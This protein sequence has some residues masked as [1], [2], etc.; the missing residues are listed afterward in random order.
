MLTLITGADGFLGGHITSMLLDE[1]YRVRALYHPRSSRGRLKRHPN[2]E[3]VEGDLLDPP[4]LNAAMEGVDC[5][6]HT[7]ANTSL[8]PRK[9]PQIWNINFHGTRNLA[10]CA[11]S[12]SVR[13]FVYIGTANSFGAGT[14]DN[15]GN[16]NNPF[17][18]G[19]FGFD[20]MNSKRSA[21]EWLTRFA[22]EKGFPVIV[23]N[24]CYMI[25]PGDSKPGSGMLLLRL[26]RSPVLP[27]PRGGRNFVHVK[28][29]A[30]AAVNA[31]KMGRIG[32]CYICGNENLP[33]K[34]AFPLF[35]RVMNRRI[36]AVWIPAPLVLLL[37]AVNSLIAKITGRETSV[38]YVISRTSLQ[39]S[40]YSAEKARTE[41]DMPQTPL[42]DAAREAFI[43]FK[44][45]GYCD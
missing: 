7:A 3:I 30:R 11:Y 34:R 38:S 21:Q 31:L 39:G 32:E 23:L 40:Y 19:R 27:I 35:A 37:G 25:G 20:Y 1:G 6:I 17:L 16:E 29:V 36:P 22:A 10:E 4:S 28:D 41:L 15:P 12:H 13:R 26:Y 33:Y 18:D 24:P 44:E 2:L 9:Q 8:Y 5:I 42:E 43:W 45:N 14:L